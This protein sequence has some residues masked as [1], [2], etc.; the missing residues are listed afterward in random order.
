MIAWGV[1]LVSSDARA[2][3]AGSVP[4][5]SS[6]GD[7]PWLAHGFLSLSSLAEA[8]VQPQALFDRGEV[9]SKAM[10]RMKS[11][12]ELIIVAEVCESLDQAGTWDFLYG[13]RVLVAT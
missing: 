11:S 8:A 5:P 9:A 6:D 3:G 4:G 12:E 1:I 7:A 2:A 10:R 13:L